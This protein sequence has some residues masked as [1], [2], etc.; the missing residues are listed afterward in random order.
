MALTKLVSAYHRHTKTPAV[1]ALLVLPLFLLYGL[2]LLIASPQARSGVDF[3][4]G[5]LLATFGEDGYTWTV[6]GLASLTLVF[7]VY[8]LRR[9]T[10]RRAALLVP[11]S[12]ET[13][14]YAVSMGALILAVMEEAHLLGPI[15]MDAELVDRTVIAAG[16]GFHE[17]LLFRLAAIPL[18]ALLCERG[19]A[20]PRSLAI[21]TALVASS[22]LFAAAHHLAG[23]P[24]DAF[25]FSYRTLAG[26]VFAGL[27]IARGFAVAAW[28]HAIYDFYVLTVYAE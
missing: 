10:A 9:D 6:V 5:S 25:A 18:L 21:I 16:A 24:F 1:S 11:M 27:F 23:E 22:L 4:S 12:L 2:G 20:M 13:S 8:R 28:T 17:E 14:V 19:L 15:L 26:A 7:T 3:V